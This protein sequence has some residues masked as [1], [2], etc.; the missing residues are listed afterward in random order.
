[1]F[2]NLSIQGGS[3]G[4]KV[5]FIE[6]ETARYRGRSADEKGAKRERPAPPLRRRVVSRM[7]EFNA[8]HAGGFAIPGGAKGPGNDGVLGG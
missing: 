2:A 8:C 6:G 5:T 4:A 3:H 7:A 1:M